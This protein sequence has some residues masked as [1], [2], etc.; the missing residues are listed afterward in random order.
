MATLLSGMMIKW[1]TKNSSLHLGATLEVGKKAIEL[2]LPYPHIFKKAPE[3]Y[4]NL[5]VLLQREYF[6]K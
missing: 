6:S 5:L 3:A 2:F 1:M 4:Q